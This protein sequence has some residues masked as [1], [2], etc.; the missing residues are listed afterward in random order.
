[1]SI[2][3]PRSVM[4]ARNTLSDLRELVRRELDGVVVGSD[5]PLDLL[6]LA[7]VCG[8]HVLIEGPPGVAKTLMAG[9]MARVL[10]VNFKRV[11]FTPDTSPQELTGKTVMRGG[12]S[13]FQPGAAFTNMLLADEINRTPPLFDQA[14]LLEGDAGAAR[15]GR[16]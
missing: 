1:M 13:I 12:E 16:R 8:G 11:Q 2:S 10:G 5:E 3:V 9:S 7:A 6:L 15:H 4:D 14:A